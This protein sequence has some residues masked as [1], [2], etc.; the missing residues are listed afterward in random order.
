MA[1]YYSR[2]AL[3]LLEK[4][5]GTREKAKKLLAENKEILDRFEQELAAARA[6]LE[7]E[8]DTAAMETAMEM[9]KTE[10]GTPGDEELSAAQ[11]GAQQTEEDFD[12][13]EEAF[14]K[15]LKDQND[16]L[17]QKGVILDDEDDDLE[18]DHD[19]IQ[20]MI[21]QK[22]EEKQRKAAQEL[23]SRPRNRKVKQPQFF[24]PMPTPGPLPTPPGSSAPGSS[25]ME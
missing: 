4:L 11:P 20:L 14:F 6:K 22:E 24:L 8:P 2:K 12:A 1:V 23:A 25:A 17:R 15:A 16:E 9:D 5:D 7:E 21:V 18:L 3:A 19:P 10:T 13:D